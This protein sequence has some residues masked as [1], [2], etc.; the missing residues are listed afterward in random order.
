[1]S[2]QLPRGTVLSP[3][4]NYAHSYGTWLASIREND[5][6][7]HCVGRIGCFMYALVVNLL[8]SCA[9]DCQVTCLLCCSNCSSSIS[10]LLGKGV[11]DLQLNYERTREEMSCSH[12]ASG[13]FSTRYT[14]KDLHFKKLLCMQ[15]FFF[16]TWMKN[17]CH[18]FNSSHERK[19]KGHDLVE[20]LT[21]YLGA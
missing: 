4:V 11:I 21:D 13:N 12:E 1:M 5:K 9:M 17:V 14:V 3:G 7:E 20:Q 2:G 6:M 8:Q 19:W 16:L 15:F 18:S 10:S